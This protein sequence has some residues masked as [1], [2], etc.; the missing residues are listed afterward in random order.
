MSFAISTG[1][2]WLV[3][4][5]SSGLGLEICN[6]AQR[7]GHIVIATSRNSSKTPDVVATIEE[8][9]GHWLAMDVTSPQLDKQVDQALALYGK[10]DVLVNNA[11][12][13]T[14]GAIEDHRC[15]DD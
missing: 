15:V 1:K 4:G 10:I 3:T 11:G 6:A 14:C 2:V 7:A 8:K 9:G 5:C 13:A 12:F